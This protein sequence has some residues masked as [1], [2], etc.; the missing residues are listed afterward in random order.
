MSDRVRNV[1]EQILSDNYYVLREASFELR[2]SDGTWTTQQREAYD[3]G[4]G[5]AILLHDPDRETVLLIRQ[6]RWPTYVNGNPGGMLLEVPAGLLDEDDPEPAVRR[7][8]L[9]ETGLESARSAT[10]SMPT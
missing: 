8:V 6:F 10:S 9:E 1:S 5:A 7:E 4:N 3:R 2:G